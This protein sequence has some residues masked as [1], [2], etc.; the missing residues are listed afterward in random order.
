MSICIIA[1]SRSVTNYKTVEAAIN[2]S[3]FFDKITEIVS[4]TCRGPDLFGE[5][6]AREHNISIKRFPP[7]WNKYGRAAGHIRNEQMAK[8]VKDSGGGYLIAVMEKNGSP[9]SKSM[10]RL[11]KQYGLTVYIYLVY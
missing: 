9:G 4:G 2:G 1:G 3:P 7:D 10:I 6:Y 11:A 8:Y 5:Q